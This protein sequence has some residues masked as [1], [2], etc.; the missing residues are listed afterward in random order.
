MNWLVEG[1]TSLRNGFFKRNIIM[2]ENEVNSF[3][4]KY[5]NIDVYITAWKYDHR[6]QKTA[7]IIGD[8]YFDFDSQNLDHV[9]ADAIKAIEFITTQLRVPSSQIRLYF[10]GSKGVHIIVPYQT[11]NI[12]PHENLNLVYRIIAEEIWENWCPYKTIDLAIYDKKR[13]FRMP[14]SINSKTGL[15]KIPIT[16]NELKE[17]DWDTIKR[18]AIE[19]RVVKHEEPRLSYQCMGVMKQ[20][21]DKMYAKLAERKRKI[22]NAKPLDYV[23]PCIDYLLTNSTSEGNRNNILSILCSHFRQRGMDE[24]QAWSNILKWN[25]EQC[26]PPMDYDELERT[27]NSIFHGEYTYGVSHIKLVAPCEQDGCR[28]CKPKL[29]GGIK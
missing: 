25:D 11:L 3:R 17:L 23:P 19:P 7:K 24:E 14:N 6:E 27:F 2:N 26:D 5:D 28:L 22:E 9:R 15:Y 13:L 18:L 1:G 21:L 20:Y 8:L 16:I 12:T 29:G 4:F 10:S